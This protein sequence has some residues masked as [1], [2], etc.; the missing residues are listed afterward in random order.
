MTFIKKYKYNIL[1]FFIPVLIFS[2]GL[3]TYQCFFGM[4][5]S[6]LIADL[7]AQ[8]ISLFSYLKDLILGENSLFYSFSKGLG[9]NII[10]TFSYYLSSPLNFLVLLFTKKSLESFI[11]V[12]LLAKIGLSGFTMYLFLSA[13]VLENKRTIPFVLSVC[14]ALNSYMINYYFN[15]MWLDAL[16]LLPLVLLGIDKLLEGKKSILYLSSLLLTVFCNY[17]I[18][19]MVCIFSVIYFAYKLF[20]QYSIKRDR[21]IML[22]KTGVFI[23][24]SILAVLIT[25]ILLIPTILDLQN[26][27]RSFGSLTSNLFNNFSNIF[28]ISSRLFIGSNESSNLLSSDNVNIYCGL[29]IIPLVYFYFI[30]K[31]INKKEKIASAVIILIFICSICIPQLNYIWH[32]FNFPQGFPNR[33]SFM[34]IAFLIIVANKSFLTEQDNIDNN[35]YFILMIT[36]L[37]NALFTIIHKQD[38]NSLTNIYIS[39]AL[40]I[41]YI[42][43][44]YIFNHNKY[45]CYKGKICLL[46]VLICCAEM[47]ANVSSSYY[48]TF[49]GL[50][51]EYND[52]I[53][54]ITEISTKYES[55][56]DFYRIDGDFNHTDLDSLLGNYK[57]VSA[58][59][60]TNNKYALEFANIAG[61]LS[62]SNSYELTGTNTPILNNLLGVKYIITDKRISD[63]YTNINNFQYSLS[64][65]YL[66]GLINTT[67]YIYENK[68]ALSIGYMVSKDVLYIDDKIV[69]GGFYSQLYYQD[70]ILK[71]VTDSDENIFDL[72]EYSVDNYDYIVEDADGEYYIEY[73]KNTY[74]DCNTYLYLNDQLYRSDTYYGNNIAF[75]YPDEHGQIKVTFKSNKDINLLNYNNIFFYKLNQKN[76]DKAM[77]RLKEQ[78]LNV[79]EYSDGYLKGN[80]DVKES[81][82][83]FTSIP[84][85]DG[86]TILVDGQEVDYYKVLNGFIGFDL[87][88]GYHTIEMKFFPPGLK[89]GAII[90]IISILV[91]FVYA[92]YDKIILMFNKLKKV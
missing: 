23:F 85:E 72:V 13:K 25:S 79:E 22:K 46:L 78:Q 35:H 7:K 70:L 38:I 12:L 4:E 42:I 69:D 3:I 41:V 40:F 64:N 45:V 80:I 92:F 36:Y 76:L 63:N 15:I 77:D 66:Y 83:L 52:F 34:F 51:V 44:L 30:N 59:L 90:S 9:G 53:E 33:F 21:I 87:D 61:I 67:N 19:Y 31:T 89:V 14:Y 29:L 8:Y 58:F 24:L 71:S 84:Y 68:D 48:K 18:G 60:S 82:I 20:T 62:S 10:G 17:Y 49:T 39:C 11:I 55:D 86:W 56:D 65:G 32:G 73:R 27:A 43:I 81:D 37:V 50:K 28:T 2:L 57:S 54:Q 16:Y 26:T 75:V 5:K 1:S 74:A 6:L 91:S 47:F 88:E